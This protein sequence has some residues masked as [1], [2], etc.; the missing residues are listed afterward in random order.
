MCPFSYLPTSY[1]VLV[2]GKVE[3]G[4][5]GAG[6]LAGRVHYQALVPRPTPAL[7]GGEGGDG[8]GGADAPLLQAVDG[9][10]AAHRLV[11][12]VD[13]LPRDHAARLLGPGKVIVG[14]FEKSSN[15]FCFTAGCRGLNPCCGAGACGAEIILRT[16]R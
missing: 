2:P 1:A 4:A 5:G 9:R 3:V 14:K 16:R 6:P 8:G 11:Q 10:A 7:V 12:R 13:V 15:V